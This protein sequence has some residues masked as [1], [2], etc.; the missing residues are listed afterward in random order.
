MPVNIRKEEVGVKLKFQV[1]GMTCAACSARV[2][3][4]TAAVPGV[5]Q[6]EVNLLAGKMTVEASSD[7]SAAIEK[8]VK[9]AGYDEWMLWSAANKYHLH[10]S[11]EAAAP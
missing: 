9:D 5:K 1:T 10:P 7:V 8:A 2:E 11:G 4:A 3:K 6:V